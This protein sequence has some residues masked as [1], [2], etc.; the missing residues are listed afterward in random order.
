MNN[1]KIIRR[2]ITK[3]LF[4][5]GLLSA[6]TSQAAIFDRLTASPSSRDISIDR[7]VSV[8][9]TWSII[10]SHAIKAE[11]LL[12]SSASSL[13]FEDSFGNSLGTV[14]ASVFSKTVLLPQSSRV[15]TTFSETII[16]SPDVI[17]RARLN[18]S[19][20]VVIKRVFAGVL[21]EIVD[22]SKPSLISA[23]ASVSLNLNITTSI[24]SALGLSVNRLMLSFENGLLVKTV[25]RDEV[26]K[27][28]IEMD[29][30]GTGII[31]GVWEVAEPSTTRGTPFFRPMKQFSKHVS[32]EQTFEIM[33]PELPDNMDGLYL[34]RFRLIEPVLDTI[35]MVRYVVRPVATSETVKLKPVDLRG[36]ANKSHLMK[37]TEFSW[38]RIENAKYYQLEFFM[39]RNQFGLQGQEENEPNI[40]HMKRVA[41]VLV[42]GK[43]IKQRLSE[44][45]RRHFNSGYQ[46]YWHV[47][48]IDGEG[49]R[50]AKSELRKVIVP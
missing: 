32:G 2:Y 39:D 40:E 49:R 38:Q 7:Q 21:Q 36:P 41:G 4:V 27:A 33:S 1:H 16:I 14:N 12:T 23:S 44:L 37:K 47:I 11:L 19:N 13:V 35:P 34:L 5:I 24:S 6:S 31:R 42:L 48:A 50:L 29:T 46:Y 43:N 20:R 25:M 8:P 9:V 17:R 10:S 28:R 15:T 3:L 26:L 30:L 18:R 45:T 22:Q